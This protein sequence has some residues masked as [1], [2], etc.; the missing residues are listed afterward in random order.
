MKI[1][2]FFLFT[3]QQRSGIFS[4]LVIILLLQGFY[5]YIVNIIEPSKTKKEWALNAEE[6]DLFISEI[7]TLKKNKEVVSKPIIYSYNPNFITDYKGYAIG[8]SN[9]EIDRLHRFR[10]KN[11]WINSAKEFQKVTQISDSLLRI[12]SPNFKFPAWTKNSIIKANSYSKN[13]ERDFPATDIQKIDLNQATALQL[14]NVKGIGDKLSQR[15]IKYRT[16]QKGFVSSIELSEIYG[17]S[18]EVIHAI[19]KEFDVKSPKKI[20]KIV[21]NTAMRDELV[22]LKYIDYEMAYNIIEERTLRDGFKSLND[23]KKV[24]D[25]PLNK[26]EIIKLYLLLD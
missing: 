1:K 2:S 10:N 20:H 9:L 11:K 24:K 8:M 19:N 5:W 17:L 13:G 26:F 12:L 7:E 18:T 21:L 15:I 23:L 16:A 22:K 3:K 14:R 4:L 25:F 6:I